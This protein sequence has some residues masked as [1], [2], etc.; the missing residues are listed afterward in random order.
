M[1]SLHHSECIVDGR[2]RRDRNH[3][4]RHSFTDEHVY[5]QSNGAAEAAVCENCY[6]SYYITYSPKRS[7]R[8]GVQKLIL[9][10]CMFE[11]SRSLSCEGHQ[12][13][14]SEAGVLVG[15]SHLQVFINAHIC[16]QLLGQ[17]L[18][19]FPPRGASLPYFANSL[20]IRAMWRA[21]FKYRSTR[22]FSLG[23]CARVSG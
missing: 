2:I 15:R 1:F 14:V 9:A 17:A 22:M 20:S 10:F 19:P 23:A 16:E 11:P 8:I 18:C 7:H 12:Y 4:A 6:K 3:R 21:C 5:L 13:G